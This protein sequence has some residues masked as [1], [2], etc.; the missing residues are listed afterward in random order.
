[1]VCPVHPVPRCFKGQVICTIVLSGW[2]RNSPKP[3]PVII[4]MANDTIVEIVQSSPEGSADR[5]GL[6][7]RSFSGDGVDRR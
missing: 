6:A 1:M 4:T 7:L 2:L 3:L 5:V